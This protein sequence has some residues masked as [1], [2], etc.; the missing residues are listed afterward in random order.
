MYY[1]AVNRKVQYSEKARHRLPSIDSVQLVDTELLIKN[2]SALL[3]LERA[4]PADARL[5]RR[6][7]PANANHVFRPP[8]AARATAVECQTMK[9]RVLF[10][11]PA[12]LFITR[13][14]SCRSCSC[15]TS[16]SWTR[17]TCTAG[18]PCPVFG[19]YVEGVQQPDLLGKHP[20][21]LSHRRHRDRGHP[22]HRLPIAYI[23]SVSGKALATTLTVVTV[24]P[25][26]VSVVV[27]G[28]GWIIVFG[29]EAAAQRAA[30]VDRPGQPAHP[31][32]VHRVRRH[33]R[34]HAPV[35]AVHDPAGAGQPA[36]HR[37][38]HH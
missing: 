1:G 10:L 35:A 4:S 12:L 32:S 16:A 33:H 14:C 34:A 3:D 36:G 11:S 15:C 26:F 25:L 7:A 24:L 6:A 20:H 29:R 8:C 31:G 27:R 37:Q 38:E 22:G 5:S 17:T 30:A 13:R 28:F 19:N 23:I 18:R 21:H 2:M 9:Q